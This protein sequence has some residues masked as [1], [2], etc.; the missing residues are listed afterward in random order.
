MSSSESPISHLL[1]MLDLQHAVQLQLEELA[2][3][4]TSLLSSETFLRRELELARG[5]E[6]DYAKRTAMFKR[7]IALLVLPTALR[8]RY[9]CRVNAHTAGALISAPL[10][11]WPVMSGVHL[12]DDA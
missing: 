9:T 4:A 7:A 1:D 10:Q 12:Q 11:V 5:R 3:Q 2:Q 6:S 8:S